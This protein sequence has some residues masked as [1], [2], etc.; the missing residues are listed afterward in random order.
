M[1]HP[2]HYIL[3]TIICIVTGITFTACENKRDSNGEL[4]GMWQLTLWTDAQGDTVATNENAIYYHFQ[5]QLMKLERM[6]NK[7]TGVYLL[8]FTHRPD[9]LIIREAYARPNDNRVELSVIRPYGIP[10]DGRFH[11]DALNDNRMQLS[12]PEGTLHF[13]KY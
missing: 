1:K 12:S 10:Q 9:S 5:L 2:I 7:G 11:I 4:G 6:D 3:Y 13:R 8:R